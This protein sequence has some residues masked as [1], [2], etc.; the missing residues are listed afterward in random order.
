M[1][2]KGLT[3]EVTPS[4]KHKEHRLDSQQL[5]SYG[6]LKFNMILTLSRTTESFVLLERHKTRL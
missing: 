1:S 3:P 4:Q 2:V 5:Q 6:Y